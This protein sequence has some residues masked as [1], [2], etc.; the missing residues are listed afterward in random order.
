[1]L[2]MKKKETG[3]RY[4][5]L[6]RYYSKIEVDKIQKCHFWPEKNAWRK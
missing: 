6:F 5:K 3:V 1:M 2:S 4:I